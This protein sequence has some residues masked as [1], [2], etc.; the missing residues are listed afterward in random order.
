MMKLQIL[1]GA[2]AL[3]AWTMSAPSHAI[4]L[5]QIDNFSS[6][7][8]GW[9]AG[10]GPL[11]QFPPVP[12][13]VVGTG[14]PGGAGDAF[15]VIT[16]DGNAGAGGRLVAMN[17]LGQWSGDYTA[18]GVTG[19]SMDLKNLGSTDLTVRLYFEDPI[20]DP[21]LNEAVSGGLLLPAGADW[22][23]AVFP[24]SA[25]ALTVLQGSADAVLGNTRVLRVFSNAAADFPPERLVG[26]LGV[27]N[28]QAVPE[29]STSATLLGGLAL[30]AS[31]ACR[32]R[33][34]A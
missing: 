27:D 9:S 8:Q 20:P 12:P 2:V 11:G 6:G 19:I 31:M 28:I 24:V 13:T 29:P 16:S 4:T 25:A 1:C 22:T 23:H 7:V 14:G 33:R 26:V 32:R 21:P 5:G 15:L 34:R 17:V 10:G 3:A 18:A 30:L